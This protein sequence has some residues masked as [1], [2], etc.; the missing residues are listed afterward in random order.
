MLLTACGGGV[1]S[2]PPPQ[3]ALTANVRFVNVSPDAGVPDPS[4]SQNELILFSSAAAQVTVDSAQVATLAGDSGLST[5]SGGTTPVVPSV[6][7]YTTIP[8]SSHAVA[9]VDPSAYT[10]SG[11]L[12]ISTTLQT[13]KAGG[14]Y[15]IVLA[16]S[17]CL[18]TLQ[19]YQFADTQTT[20]GRVVMYN[21]APDN[22]GA[23]QFGTFPT[24]T[25]APLS[26]LG[27]AAPGARAEGSI[28]AT[29]IGAYAGSGGTF[30][31]LPSAVLSFDTNNAVPY[32]ALTTFALFYRDGIP[33]NA[34]SVDC[35]TKAATT[36]FLQG[37]M[38]N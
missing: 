35:S 37:A 26:A 20:S 38:T 2:A 8:A 5:T 23:I 22:P 6:T 1:S 4:N 34:S 27:T 33:Q 16:G 32:N 11:F 14:Y 36:P 25:G 29:G 28:S 19:F 12:Q 15:T 21:V 13:M 18:G 24:A 3:G 30:Q 31:L 10:A 17:Y 7:A 9:Y